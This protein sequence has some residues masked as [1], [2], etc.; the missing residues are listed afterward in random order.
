MQWAVEL[1][2]VSKAF[3]I[4]RNAVSSL[5]ERVIGI[6]S[7]RQR[8]RRER[9]WALQGVNLSVRAGEFLGLIGPNGSG[10]STLL[11]LLAG[12]FPPTTGTVKVR[13]RTAPMIELGVGFHPDLTGRE[14]IYLNTSLFRLSKRD[15]DAIYAQIVAFA[16]LDD[17]IDQPVKNYSSGMY[18]RLGFA[19]AVHLHPDVLLIDE[20]LAVGDEHFTRRCL[21]RMDDIRRDGKTIVL[22]SHSMNVVEQLCDRACLLVHGRVE[23][24]GR[25]AEVIALYRELTDAMNGEA[26]ACAVAAQ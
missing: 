6:V 26:T 4:R 19:V 18:M 9:F 10:K 13:G 11:R 16:E 21:Q 2:G 7:A 5:K 20:V 24:D 12:I 3:V 23:A 25:P 8:E 17:F 22:V 15:T 1:N 14:N